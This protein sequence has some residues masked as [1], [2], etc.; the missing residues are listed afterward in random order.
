ME[1]HRERAT[2]QEGAVTERQRW[3]EAGPVNGSI[4]VRRTQTLPSL[5]RS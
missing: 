2:E 5:E 1:A 3:D 4:K